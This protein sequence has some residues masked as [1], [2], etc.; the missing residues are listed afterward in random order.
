MKAG[1]QLISTTILGCA[2]LC[3]LAALAPAAF[4]AAAAPLPRCVA[5]APLPDT[6][7]DP[8]ADARREALCAIDFTSADTAVCPKNWSTSAA[9]LVYDL[10]GTPWS[11]R[12]A[13]FETE[14]CRR[15]TRARDAAAKELAV[16]KHSMNDPQTSGTYAPAALLYDHLAR[17]LGV[18]VRVPVAV[19][20][21]FPVDWYAGRVAEPG[22]ALAREQPSRKMLLAAWTVLAAVLEP[23][24]THP[25][26]AEILLPDE[27]ALWGA[28]LL[29]TGRRYGPEMN[30]TRESGWGAGQNYDFQHTAPFITLRTPGELDAAV[31]QGL[32]EAR[33]DPRMAEAL[34]AD[35]AP[36]QVKWW[37]AEV[38]DIVVLDYLL[39]QQD[40]IGNIDYEWRW[41]WLEDG[42]VRSAHATGAPPQPGAARLRITWLNDNDAGIRHG[43][44][45][46]ARQTGMIE[47]LRHFDPALY[48]R[49]K[50]LAADFAAQGPVYRAIASNYHL[51]EREL[52]AIGKR[53]AAL[54]RTIT[55][56]CEAGNYRFD[57]TAARLLGG[58]GTRADAPACR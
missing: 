6:P 21:R 4:G 2:A 3:G 56:A 44:A 53:L 8:V 41:V 15:G 23:P 39:G 5:V 1:G 43:Y 40:R 52:A 11:G 26:A 7:A 19:E 31:E 46:Y 34:P 55:A 29:F 54:D 13:A 25:E 37:A 17:W 48:R 33:Q 47:G 42:A 10:G 22:L 50:V 16:F 14:V 27:G 51:P 49:L 9:A 45:N 35:I 30:G 20:H 18:R 32:A 38:L 36:V 57:L 24:R 12:R 28:S 58:T